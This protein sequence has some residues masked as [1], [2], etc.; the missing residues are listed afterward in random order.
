MAGR[1]GAGTSGEIGTHTGN[2]QRHA[3]QDQQDAQHD[4]AEGDQFLNFPAADDAKLFS[5]KTN[6]QH[7]RECPHGVPRRGGEKNRRPGDQRRPTLQS[8]QSERLSDQTSRKPSFDDG[9]HPP[10]SEE[11]QAQ[12]C[13]RVVETSAGFAVGWLNWGFYDHPEATDVSQLTAC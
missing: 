1:S 12:W 2:A 3:A 6:P 11:Q 10:A 4:Q 5:N 13:R 9:R 7:H 8:G